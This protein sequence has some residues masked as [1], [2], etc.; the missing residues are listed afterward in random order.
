LAPTLLD[1]ETLPYGGDSKMV[2]NKAARP[3]AFYFTPAEGLLEDEKMD[4][5][6]LLVWES[7]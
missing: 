6:L 4:S 2:I 7:L 1:Y 3:D 5:L